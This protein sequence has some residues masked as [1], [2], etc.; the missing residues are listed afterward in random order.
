[1]NR[2]KVV[3]FLNHAAEMGG[4]EF[5]LAR[6]VG[7]LDRSQWHPVVVFGEEGPAVELLRE[8]SVETYVIPLGAGLGKVRRENLGSPAWL[9]G[10]RAIAAARYVVRLSRFFKERAVELV[11]TNSMKAHVLGG[12]AAKLS[13]IPLV[14]HL[15]DS[16]H[17]MC[18]PP[19]ALA[20]MRWLAWHLPDELITVSRSVAKDALGGA[21]A[22]Y[23]RV[24]YDGLDEGCFPAMTAPPPRPYQGSKWTVGIAGRLCAWKGQHLFLEAAANL[25]ESGMQ[26]RFELLGGPLFGQEAYAERLKQFAASS[27]LSEHIHFHGFVSDVPARI[28]SWD[29]LVHASTAPD[30]CPNVVLE[31]MAA[32]VPVV[33]ADGGGVPELLEGGSCGMLFPRDDSRA[34][35]RCIESALLD[36]P[37]RDRFARLARERAERC[38]RSER[39]GKEVASVWAPLTR[40]G[41]H[42]RRAWPW[43]ENGISGDCGSLPPKSGEKGTTQQSIP[44]T[45]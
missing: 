21:K 30:P 34:L 26:I 9:L 31:A 18:L 45:A 8:Q 44:Y 22:H 35:S 12:V 32:G 11:H 17:P 43:I 3:C 41:P 37:R 4:A 24:I 27:G 19:C 7:A 29:L 39:V 40:P 13:G 20:G 6:L 23:A 28:R 10:G 42:E 15:R 16:L 33:G 5:A 1:M 25:L 38:F 2:E 36:K 14:W